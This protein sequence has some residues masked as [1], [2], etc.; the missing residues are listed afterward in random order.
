MPP[1]SKK[2]DDSIVPH[3]GQYPALS[4]PGKN[5]PLPPAR[6]LLG[7]AQVASRAC[8]GS[9]TPKEDHPINTEVCSQH[10]RSWLGP[11]AL[12]AC[13]RKKR[14]AL[15]GWMMSRFEAED[16]AGFEFWRLFGVKVTGF[17]TGW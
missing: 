14:D 9:N 5:A 6:R 10:Q 4:R 3:C 8:K 1:F 7:M 17:G 2:V 11:G 12:P 16:E 15:Y 13:T